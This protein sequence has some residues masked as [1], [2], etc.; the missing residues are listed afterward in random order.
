MTAKG[1]AHTLFIAT[2]GGLNLHHPLSGPQTCCPAEVA[3]KE[4]AFSSAE[5]E[6]FENP[7]VGGVSVF[8]L[9]FFLFVGGC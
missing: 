2:L 9:V 6:S 4:A 1:H 3:P 5:S 8:E 7:G